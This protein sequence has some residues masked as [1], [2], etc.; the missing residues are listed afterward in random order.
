MMPG[1]SPDQAPE[2]EIGDE[3]CPICGEVYECDEAVHSRLGAVDSPDQWPHLSTYLD[4]QSRKMMR[5]AEIADRR[6]ETH[7]SGEGAPF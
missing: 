6:R 2:P 4:V 1:Y 7:N 5:L 3:P